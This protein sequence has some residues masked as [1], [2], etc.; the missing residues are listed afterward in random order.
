MSSKEQKTPEGQAPEEI[1]TE[2][3][4]EV[5]AVEPDAS[6]EQVDPRDEKIANLEAQLVE[7]Q[8]RER[9]GVL[10][11]KA[12]MENLRRRTEQDVEKAHKFALEKFVNELLPVI[13][14]LDRA[15]EV[16]DKA[17]PDN[18]AMIEGIELTLKS[19][20]D[21]V[22]KFGVEVI[23]DTNVPLDPNV[24]QAIAMVESE[25]VEAGKV[26]GVMQKGYTLNGRTI[27]AA[28]V[29]VAKAKA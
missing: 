9:D 14:S 13:D 26:L 5:E 17:N 23:A 16:A 29:T 27:R 6:A 22:R 4:D 21:V 20:L 7:A 24:H 8:N 18:A 1:I 19:M 12:E 15:L 11:I 28:M 25:E 3:H 10:R 2:Q